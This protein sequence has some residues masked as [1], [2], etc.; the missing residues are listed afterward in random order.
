MVNDDE[1]GLIRSVA[2]QNAQSIHLARERAEEALRA[3]T[4]WLRVTLASIGD[5]VIT[6]GADGRVTFLNRVAETLTGW[7]E[8]EAIGLPLSDVF[9]IV[10]EATRQPVENPALRALREGMVVGLANHTILLAKDGTERPIDDSAAPMRDETGRVVGTVL[11][12][13]DITERRR[14]EFEREQ[15]LREV[16]TERKRLAEVFERSP[17]FVAILRGPEHVFERANNRYYQL[18]GHRDII[19]KP[20][21]AALPEL[22]SQGFFEL[23]DNVYRTGE[24]YAAMDARIFLRPEAE[25]SL[26]EFH[27]EYVFQPLRDSDG[28]VS[29]VL[30]HGID[31]T[32]RMKADESLRRV[33]AESEQ[34][35]RLYETLLSSTPDFG[36]VFS[37]DHRFLY[38]NEALL[39]M[40]GRGWDD[41]IGK[42]FLEVGYEPWHAEMHDREID[43]V[44]TTKK[45]IR[46]EVPFTGT[47]GRRIYQPVEKADF[48]RDLGSVLSCDAAAVHF[49]PRASNRQTQ[50]PRTLHSHNT[51]AKTAPPPPCS[52]R[53]LP[54]PNRLRITTPKL[55]AAT[56]TR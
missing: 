2:L 36:Y 9:R 47:L 44:R 23:L 41:I 26:K 19:G 48:Q 22:V 28:A 35:K 50:R 8:T 31:L 14:A 42:S 52:T 20:I 27:L 39:S 16:Q 10:N 37:L 32:A 46:G 24:A 15:L 43:Q 53:G 56:C 30:V 18:I 54:T 1:D 55:N 4:E 3:Q 51:H 34:R 38:A 45:S 13:R 29:G 33:T 21:R 49:V 7:T 12:F 11:V 5:A 17:A 40:Y 25:G 6:T